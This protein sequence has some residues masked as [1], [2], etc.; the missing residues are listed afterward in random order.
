MNYVYDPQHQGPDR[1]LQQ[2]M[3]PRSTG[4]RESLQ[5]TNPT[6]STIVDLPTDQT[7]QVL[8]SQRHR[9]EGRRDPGVPGVLRD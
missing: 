7:R 8:T 5:K 1:V 4:V 3:S 2:P 9:E 6:W